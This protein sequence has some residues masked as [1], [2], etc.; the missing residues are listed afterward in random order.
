MAI[1]RD[2]VEAQ[3][4]AQ[5]NQPQYVSS[6]YSMKVHDYAVISDTSGGA[7]TIT[8]P[9]VAEAK[10]KSYMISFGGSGTTTLTIQ[11]LAGDAGYSD[12]TLNNLNEQ[13]FLYSNGERWIEV[14]KE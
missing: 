10:G 4:Y 8:L 3:I 1:L 6:A 9:P 13:L 2:V 14:I 11:D 12:Q 5:Q 7:F